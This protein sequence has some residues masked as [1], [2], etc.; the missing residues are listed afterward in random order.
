MLITTWPLFTEIKKVGTPGT[1]VELDV[2]DGEPDYDHP[3][4]DESRSP[5]SVWQIESDPQALTTK[6]LH[7]GLSNG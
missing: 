5:T 3:D 1:F 7:I 6:K 4:F 2:G